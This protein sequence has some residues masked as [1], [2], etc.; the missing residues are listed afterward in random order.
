MLK[1][2]L[3]R[4]WLNDG[5]RISFIE[6]GG[7]VLC[8]TPAAGPLDDQRQHESKTAQKAHRWV[9]REVVQ[10]MERRTLC[11]RSRNSGKLVDV[12]AEE[13]SLTGISGPPAW[14]KG[15]HPLTVFGVL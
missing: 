5:V 8:T 2:A 1:A 14:F 11:G 3:P 12:S 9:R 4:V 6:N 10:V 7:L 15:V 13:T